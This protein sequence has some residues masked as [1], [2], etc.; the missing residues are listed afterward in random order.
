MGCGC[1]K[2]RQQ[3]LAQQTPSTIQL[4]NIPTQPEQRVISEDE[5]RIIEQIKEELLR[6]HAQNQ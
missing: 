4:P 1:K 6:L 3:Q 2:R 5:K